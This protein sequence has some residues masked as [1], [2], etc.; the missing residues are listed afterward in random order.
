MLLVIWAHTASGDGP[1]LGNFGVG[2]Y[3]V[4]LFFVLSGFLITGILL[5][6]RDSGAPLTT[7]LKT[8]YARRFLRIFPAYYALLALLV[9]V[10]YPTVN[11]GLL[12]HALFLSNWHFI[13]Q[14]PPYYLGHLWSLAVEEQ[15]YLA[16]PLLVLSMSPRRLPWM[17][18]ALIVLAPLSRLALA[19]SDVNL[20]AVQVATTS[21]LDVL[22]VGALL[23]WHRH[24]FPLAIAA[25]TR[26]TGH[27]IRL[28]LGLAGLI[29]ALSLAGRG[30]VV[31][32]V[33]ETLSVALASAWIVDR[34]A[35]GVAGVSR[36][37]LEWPPIAYVGAISYG[38]Y[39]L[40]SPVRVTIWFATG[41][42]GIGQAGLP[43]FLVTSALSVALATLSW[44][45]IEQPIRSLKRFFPY[46]A[47]R[48][49][50]SVVE[51]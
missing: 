51:S 42:T 13:S 48:V 41:W 38:I 36:A 8:F 28:A 17:F 3:G 5:R 44:R 12:A 14:G 30:R 26:M 27:A 47:T 46:R 9:V 35:T 2:P 45:A 40:Q 34:C 39:L 32:A 43:L 21:N 33:V 18:G 11:D 22:G 6:L 1:R 20:L 24:T 7:A 4:W 23:A 37:I 16:W 15:F 10:G 19:L 25:R 50:P 49:D 29:V 31:L